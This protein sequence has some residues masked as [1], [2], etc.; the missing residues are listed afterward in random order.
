M[1]LCCG[2]RCADEEESHR[3]GGGRW[4]HGASDRLQR[5]TIGAAPGPNIRRREA[6]PLLSRAGG[7]TACTSAPG[8]LPTC[9]RASS[10][11][12][13]GRIPDLSRISSHTHKSIT[14]PASRL[15]YGRNLRR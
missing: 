1:F 6:H 11:S 7:K 10:T 5:H 2:A 14:F 13:L 15:S 12:A 4:R 9:S 8:P 3:G